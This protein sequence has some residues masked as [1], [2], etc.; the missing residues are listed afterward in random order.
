MK[1]VPSTSTT[2]SVPAAAEAVG[3][4]RPTVDAWVRSGVITPTGQ[5]N[6]KI[7]FSLADIENLRKVKEQRAAAREVLNLRPV[8]KS[9]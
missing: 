2:F 7:A 6:G 3:V 4:S 5:H 9:S 1:P 8:A